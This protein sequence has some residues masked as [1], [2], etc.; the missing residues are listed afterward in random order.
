MWEDVCKDNDQKWDQMMKQLRIKVFPA[1][2]KSDLKLANKHS[3]KEVWEY[4]CD[5]DPK[6]KAADIYAD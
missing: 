2:V 3:W 1:E 5:L 4:L 6:V